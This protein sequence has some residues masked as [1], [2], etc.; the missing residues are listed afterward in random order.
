MRRAHR[1]GH[2]V[3]RIGWLRAAV[4]G[5]NDG[6]ISTASLILGVAAAD[7]TKS[8]ILGEADILRRPPRNP[9]EPLLGAPQW[10]F[11]GGYGTL[12]T[13]STLAALVIGG[14]GLG[15]E[16][17]ALVS[18]SFLTLAFAQLWHVFNMRGRGSP[19]FCNAVVRNPY[20]WLA[21]GLCVA[22]LLLAIYL[23]IVAEALRVVPP[24]GAGWLLV[25]TASLAPIFA[26]LAIGALRASARKTSLG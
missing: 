24:D 21:V 10:I 16:G 23:P 6:I 14:Y 13:A 5:A 12:L 19:V 25:M 15:L 11:I 18:V 20:V 26:G 3:E 9:R 1:E 22:I 2:L 7:A 8:D 4:L 17:D